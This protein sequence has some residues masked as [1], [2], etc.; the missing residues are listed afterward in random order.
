[1]A[2]NIKNLSSFTKISFYFSVG[3]NDYIVKDDAVSLDDFKIQRKAK[4]K[5]EC[6]YTGGLYPG[7]G[8]EIISKIAFKNPKVKFT[9][10][11]DRLKANHDVIS[12]VPKNVFI[13]GF[14]PYNKIPKF[15]TIQNNFDAI[16]RKNYD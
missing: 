14:I 4:I 7:K 6:L 12:G 10:Y 16:F 8:L 3:K 5:D 11:G 2:Q 13:K 15:E 9:V 1:M